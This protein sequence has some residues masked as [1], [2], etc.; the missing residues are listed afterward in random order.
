MGLADLH[1][2]S[3]FS[4]DGTATVPVILKHAKRIGLDIIAITDHDV[5]RGSLLAAELA[6]EYGIQAIPGIEI[7]TAEGDLLALAVQKLIPAGLSLMETLM[8]V[9]EQGGF[10]IAPHPMSDGI[11]MHSLGAFAIRQALRDPDAARILIG[12]ETYNAMLLDRDSNDAARILAERS[13]IAQTGSS[14]AHIVNAVGLGATVFP[15]DTVLQLA[16]ALWT[17]ATQVRKGP[18]WGPVRVLGS[19][20]ACSM[21]KNARLSGEAVAARIAHTKE[22]WPWNFSWVSR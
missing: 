22:V 3:I 4:H 5:I 16:A 9:G 20:A 18:E 10:C 1:I 14:D 17:G 15:G 12:I 21:M 2:H 13:D 19:W 11:R 8:L 6:P 7:T